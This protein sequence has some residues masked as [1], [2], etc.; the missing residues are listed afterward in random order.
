MR[1]YLPAV[2]WMRE[3]GVPTSEQ[4]GPI[5]SIGIGYPIKIPDLYQVHAKQIADS[6]TGSRV[7]TNTKVVK[8]LQEVPGVA[9][10]P[11]IGAI[12]QKISPDGKPS[13]LIEVKAKLVVMATGG[14]QGSPGLRAKF[15]GPAG[16]NLF[17]RSNKGSVGDG[18]T[19]ASSAG[20]ST[21]RGMATYYGHLMAS[22][23]RVEDVSPEEYLPLAQ[24]RMKLFPKSRY[25]DMDDADVE[26]M[27]TESRRC[28]LINER[29]QRFADETLGDEIVNQYLT[30]QENRRGFILFR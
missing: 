2:Q 1:D 11:V 5:M 23:L 30:K 3:N 14:F 29:G 4:F 26:S 20:A 27:V 9:G 28:I 12:L 16:D 10:S 6:N 13:E 25:Q 19:L 17:V 8:I 7:L 18:L 15:L 24:Y 22:P 21:S